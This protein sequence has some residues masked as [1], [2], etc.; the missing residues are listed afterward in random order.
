M[1]RQHHK[2]T[3]GR[4]QL[5]DHRRVKTWFEI[6]KGRDRMPEDILLGGKQKTNLEVGRVFGWSEIQQVKYCVY[7]VSES[8][9]RHLPP[10]L[11][12]PAAQVYIT[13]EVCWSLATWHDQLHWI[14]MF[15]SYTILNCFLLGIDLAES[16]WIED[17]TPWKDVFPNSPEDWL[18]R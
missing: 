7:I 13:C 1:K 12:Q 5:S 11:Q 8:L 4:S 6:W 18:R 15:Y 16:V 14:N 17:L 2:I 9:P 10:P 3:D